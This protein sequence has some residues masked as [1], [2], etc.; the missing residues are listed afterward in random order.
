MGKIR[1]LA[2][3][4][5]V[6]TVQRP[7]VMFKKPPVKS[8][9]E[10][11]R[12]K[13]LT[14]S[15]QH[16]NQVSQCRLPRKTVYEPKRPELLGRLVQPKASAKLDRSA[17]STSILDKSL[18]HRSFGPNKDILQKKG[19]KSQLDDEAF[20]PGRKALDRF[21]ANP[22]TPGSD[23]H[24]SLLPKELVNVKLDG[25]YVAMFKAMNSA[26]KLAAESKIK[27]EAKTPEKAVEH[28]ESTVERRLSS[29]MKSSSRI[30]TNHVRFA[31]ILEEEPSSSE[32]RSVDRDPSKA[33]PNEGSN[34]PTSVDKISEAVNALT[35]DEGE[36][37]KALQRLD[38]DALLRL[39]KVVNELAATPTVTG[40]DGKENVETPAEKPL[41]TETPKRKVRTT[42]SPANIFAPR[43]V[44]ETNKHPPERHDNLNRHANP[45]TKNSF[46]AA[47][48][49]CH[50]KSP[51][52]ENMKE[53]KL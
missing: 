6:P 34:E 52:S 22:M 47:T 7:P 45:S 42:I 12:R 53:N 26:R 33:T 17:H 14:E 3:T 10:E 37:S 16:Y 41:S 18:P 20:L 19:A 24:H 39:K 25:D 31:E 44:N 46:T 40:A 5:N 1:R 21:R 32:S 27:M 30:R 48:Q 23:R 35:L 9:V 28:K 15:R 50:V 11:E 13:R 2:N 29:I 38:R 4:A 51:T 36:L 8:T 49:F 43:E